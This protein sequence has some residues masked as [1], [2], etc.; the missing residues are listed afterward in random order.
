MQLP[1]YP[2]ENVL[3]D[4]IAEFFKCTCED[5]APFL[6]TLFNENNVFFPEC[7]GQSI[8]SHIFKS[9]VVSDPCIYRGISVTYTMYKIFSYIM[10]KRL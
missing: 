10:N 4:L 9:G 3:V 8:I 5:I 7:S 2:L 1:I 6:C